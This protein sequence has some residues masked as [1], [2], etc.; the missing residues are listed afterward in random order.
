MTAAVLKFKHR[1][2]GSLQSLIN[3]M[4]E[5]PPEQLYADD[6]LCSLVGNEGDLP[7]SLYVAYDAEGEFVNFIICELGAEAEGVWMTLTSK[8]ATA[9]GKAL[10]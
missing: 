7:G 10:L 4:P 9:L 5:T 6:V 1:I 3:S 2:D 8:Q